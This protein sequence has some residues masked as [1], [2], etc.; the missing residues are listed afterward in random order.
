MLRLG[1][2]AT[3]FIPLCSA[4]LHFLVSLWVFL[5][6]VVNDSKP[7]VSPLYSIE[8]ITS[9]NHLYF[10]LEAEFVRNLFFSNGYPLPLIQSIFTKF[11]SSKSD[12]QDPGLTAP[13]KP[14]YF[15]IPYFGHKSVSLKIELTNLISE[16]FPHLDPKLILVN[17]LSISSFFQFKDALPT[18]LRSCVIYKFCCAQ[19]CAS[20]YVGSTMRMLGTRIA[21]HRGLSIRTGQ[22]LLHPPQSSIRHHCDSLA[23]D[24]SPQNFNI[25]ATCNNFLDLRISESLLIKKTSP[26]LNN[27]ESAHPLLIVK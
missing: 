3:P 17:S 23:H 2:L 14:A 1:V 5:V 8:P 22:P 20:A 18:C 13:K 4:N 9:S 12:P 21:E 15:V 25:I 11:I 26:D 24:L 7:I 6:S 10:S 19:P 16:Y 27:T